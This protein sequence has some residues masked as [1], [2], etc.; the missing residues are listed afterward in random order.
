MRAQRVNADVA[1]LL[2]PSHALW[3]DADE[4][5]VSLSKAP[6]AMQPS[7]WMQGAYAARTWGGVT[8]ARLRALHNGDVVAVRAS[9]KAPRAATSSRGADAF[10][11]ACAIMLPFVP[12]APIFMGGED[13]WVNLWL[14]RADGVGPFTLTAAGIGTSERIADGVVSAAAD[15]ADGSWSVV[16]ARPLDPNAPERHVPLRPGTSWQ[17]SLCVWQGA[18][19]ERAG[20]KSFCPAW[21]DVALDP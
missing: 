4:A 2:Q 6:L 13:A 8:E 16:V 21:T 10:P 14:W 9:W 3:A 15:Y 7:P 20:L 12:D 19:A 11:D 17:V 18:Q 5:A 1:A